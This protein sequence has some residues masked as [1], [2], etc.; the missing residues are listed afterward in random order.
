MS[1][2]WL[3]GLLKAISDLPFV[4][5]AEL[6]S[7]TSSFCHTHCAGKNGKNAGI[8]SGESQ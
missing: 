4:P 3:T 2:P 6:A 5:L 8:H 1:D 7:S